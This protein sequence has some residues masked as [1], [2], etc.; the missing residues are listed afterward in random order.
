MFFCGE[1]LLAALA[2]RPD[3]MNDTDSRYDHLRSEGD[4]NISARRS[5]WA[6]THIDA[7]TQRWIDEDARVFLHQSLSTPCL[8][9]LRNCQ[10]SWIEDIAGRRLL[11]F[12]GNNVHQAGFG[13][14]K[15]V[16]AITR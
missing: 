10:G 8:N 3:P 11:D 13:H 9:V 4:I 16:E 12:H 14:P 5:A 2:V 1:N 15:I 6:R 7:E